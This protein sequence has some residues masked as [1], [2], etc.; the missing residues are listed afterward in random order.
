MRRAER[1]RRRAGRRRPAAARPPSAPR[2]TSSASS[3]VSGGRMPG[4]RRASIVLPAPGGPMR[5]RLCPPAAAISSARRAGA[6][7]RTSAQIRADV[8]GRSPAGPPAAGGAQPGHARSAAAGTSTASAQRAHRHHAASRRRPR[9]PARWRPAAA[10]PRTPRRRSRGRDRQHAARAAWIAPSSDS[11]P[12]IGDVGSRRGAAR[13]R[14]RRGCRARSAG[15]TTTPA[16]R[17]SAGARL[18][19]MRCGGK[20]EAGVAD[21][22]AHAVAALAHAGVGQARPSRKTGSPKATSTSTW[23]G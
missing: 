1:P 10:A 7:P 22:R 4:S 15:R 5:S 8:R 14:R 11:S 18:T 13:C 12:T 23:T 20:L 6:C 2:C 9:P 19:V 16:L 21:R 17:T 3:K